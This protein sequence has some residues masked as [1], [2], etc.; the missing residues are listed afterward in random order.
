[1]I[2]EIAKE[3]GFTYD[4]YPVWMSSESDSFDP[5]FLLTSGEVN[6]TLNYGMHPNDFGVNKIFGR[7]LFSPPI[8]DTSVSALVSGSGPFFVSDSSSTVKSPVE[9]NAQSKYLSI[10]VYLQANQ[11]LSTSFFCSLN[12]CMTYPVGPIVQRLLLSQNSSTATQY[13]HLFRYSQY[14]S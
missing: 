4:L 3:V 14:Q 1:M 2:D 5:V 13:A 8:Y 9:K 6:V 10:M 11:I 12:T 7:F